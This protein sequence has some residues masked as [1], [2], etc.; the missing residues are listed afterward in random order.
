MDIFATTITVMTEVYNI[1]VFIRGV[2]ADI[3]AYGSDRREI[4]D[5][6]EH[7]FLFLE[8]SKD[9]IF[10][11]YEAV[12]HNDQ[13]HINWKRDVSTILAALKKALTEYGMLAAK[14]ELLFVEDENQAERPKAKSE[15]LASFRARIK[16]C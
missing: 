8:Y 1:T 12:M 11:D 5:K 13:L 16:L 14:H 3:T 2:V 9:I 10:F 6:L 4:Q 7:E 15:A